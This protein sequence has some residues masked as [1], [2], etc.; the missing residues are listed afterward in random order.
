MLTQQMLWKKHGATTVQCLYNFHTE[1]SSY[2]T[3]FSDVTL[4]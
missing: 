2:R 1:R 4:R 3:V